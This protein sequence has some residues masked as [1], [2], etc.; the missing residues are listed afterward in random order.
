MSNNCESQIALLN[1]CR[2]NQELYIKNQWQVGYFTFLLYAAIIFASKFSG[3]GWG[4]IVLLAILCFVSVVLIIIL[5]CS[6]KEER[7]RIEKLYDVLPKI[8]DIIPKGNNSCNLKKPTSI[9]TIVLIISIIFGALI[10]IYNLWSTNNNT[11]I[12]EKISILDQK[13]DSCLNADKK[14]EIVTTELRDNSVKIISLSNVAIKR[15]DILEEKIDRINIVL[16]QK[17]V[18]KK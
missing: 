12:S 6:I 7:D 18:S 13:I 9:V 17:K 2:N 15:M 11:D 3:G 8:R 14:S 4:Y 10:S 1:I 16:Q 5:C